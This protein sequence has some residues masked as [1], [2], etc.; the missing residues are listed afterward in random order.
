MKA[1]NK[2]YFRK[3]KAAKIMS[4]PLKADLN[5]FLSAALELCGSRVVKKHIKSTMMELSSPNWYCSVA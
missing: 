3:L 4:N 5:S 1:R 2:S